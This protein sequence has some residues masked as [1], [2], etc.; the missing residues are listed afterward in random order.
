MRTVTVVATSPLLNTRR[1]NE[2]T[3]TMQYDEMT[4]KDDLMGAE[5]V[6]KISFLSFNVRPL[7]NRSTVFTIG[8]RAAI[9]REL[10]APILIPHTAKNAGKDTK[11]P[12]ETLFRSVQVCYKGLH[13]ATIIRAFAR[14]RP[15]MRIFFHALRL[16]APRYCSA[17][18]AEDNCTFGISFSPR[19]KEVG[20]GRC[21]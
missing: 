5:D 9:L 11:Y 13:V 18:C 14:R 12:Y 2:P 21:V 10:T 17:R 8:N 7:K 6:K 19:E 16:H 3:F 4:E 20:V 15:R 1:Q